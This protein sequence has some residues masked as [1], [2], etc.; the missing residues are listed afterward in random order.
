MLI[1]YP[2]YAPLSSTP[3]QNLSTAT[4]PDSSDAAAAEQSP[5]MEQIIAAEEERLAMSWDPTKLAQLAIPY[6]FHW[7]PPA[8]FV[9]VASAF[10]GLLTVIIVIMFLLRALKARR[11]KLRAEKNGTSYLKHRKL[12][13]PTT[14]I[15]DALRRGKI[16]H[17]MP[18]EDGGSEYSGKKAGSDR[19][20]HE[21]AVQ[22]G[23]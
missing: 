5:S 2:A 20:A 22:H 16:S 4:S 9:V 23:W 11:R 13:R 12:A 8:Y 6:E 18:S 7:S 14:R 3:P 15:I 21:E 10:V 17:P 19:G 1:L